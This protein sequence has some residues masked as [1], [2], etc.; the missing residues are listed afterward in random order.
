M[1][2][3]VIVHGDGRNWSVADTK[4][5]HSRAHDNPLPR[6]LRDGW[7]PVREAGFGEQVL[8]LLEKEDDAASS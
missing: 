3:Y 8:I 4:A 5:D 1:F 6:L 2:C 7:R